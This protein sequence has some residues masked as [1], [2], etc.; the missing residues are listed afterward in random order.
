MESPNRNGR[1]IFIKYGIALISGILYKITY[2][3]S[4][5][6]DSKKYAIAKN[7]DCIIWYIKNGV[8]RFFIIAAIINHTKPTPPAVK[9]V[10]E[11]IILSI[12]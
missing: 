2:T 6:V 1:G 8:T 11:D 7:I 9:Y 5:S 10:A 12:G 4:Q 3:S